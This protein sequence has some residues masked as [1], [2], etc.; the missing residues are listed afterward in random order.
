[1]G[2]IFGLGDLYGISSH[3]SQ[4]SG[5]GANKQKSFSLEVYASTSNC[6][7]ADSASLVLASLR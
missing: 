5:A 2:W 6:I 1:M 7:S 3:I 4:S